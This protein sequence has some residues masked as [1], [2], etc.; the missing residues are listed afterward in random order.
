MKLIVE[1]PETD[2]QPLEVLARRLPD[3][4]N[5][6]IYV[7]LQGFGA[8]VLGTLDEKYEGLVPYLTGRAT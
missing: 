4:A 2:D 7:S 3:G 1:I 5:I 8:R 6:Q